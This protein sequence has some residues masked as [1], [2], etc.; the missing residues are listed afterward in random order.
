M[1]HIANTK[2]EYKEEAQR[3]FSVKFQGNNFHPC[4]GLMHWVRWGRFIF[5]VRP[6]R[7]YLG[8]P[9]E[10]KELYIRGD[11]AAFEARIKEI[12]DAVGKRSFFVLNAIV[13]EMIEEEERQ[14]EIKTKRYN[15]PSI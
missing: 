9:P 13:N 14:F 6:L 15:L 11:K 5:D 4:L 10:P 12:T 7:K 3:C 2:I 1:F 8:L